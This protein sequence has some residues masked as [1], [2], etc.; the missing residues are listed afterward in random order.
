MDKMRAIQ[1]FNRAAE[2]GTFAAAARSFDVSTPAVTQLVAGLERALGTLLFHRTG[3][4]LALTADGERYY[5][6]SRPTI[7]DFLA[8]ESRL[9]PKG[10]KPRGTL[11][12]GLRSGV[13]Q[14][15]VMPRLAQFLE[16]F[17][18]VDLVARPVETLE[19][20]GD[21]GVDLVVMTGWPPDKDFV[22]RPLTQSRDLVCA[23]PQYWLREGKP[24]QPTNLRNHRCLLFRSSG[25]TILDRWSFERR[26]EIQTVD[27]SGRLMSDSL[28]WM[29]EAACAGAGVVHASDLVLIRP[30]TAGLLVPV[31]TDWEPLDSP[32]H[33]VIYR[34]A[35]RRSKLV[36]LFVDFLVEV[37][38]DL[39]AQRPAVLGHPAAGV[40]RPDWYGHARGRQSAYTQ[41]RKPRT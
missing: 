20:I 14:N 36:R 29:L 9:G 3:H 39:D 1:Y 18:D 17:P 16:R 8:V 22:V 10:V 38:A 24:D 12:I 5:E 6:V 30:I 37:F 2:L 11:T 19:E 35:L 23:A 27:V 41:R 34:P 28:P 32:S 13:G 25:G 21:Q 15:C 31:L 7:A 26:G 33:F 40:P 4:G